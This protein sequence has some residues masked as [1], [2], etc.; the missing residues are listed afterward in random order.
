MQSPPFVVSLNSLVNFIFTFPIKRPPEM[1]NDRDF[2]L[3]SADRDNP[4]GSGS[5][6][7]DDFRYPQDF[8][9][10]RHSDRL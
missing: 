9:V 7:S 6:K 10:T 8:G 1:K 2:K 5:R 4:V 3:R